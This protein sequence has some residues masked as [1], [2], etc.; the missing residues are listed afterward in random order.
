MD[1]MQ[2]FTLFKRFKNIINSA[3]FKALDNI[4]GFCHGCYKYDRNV[5]EFVICPSDLKRTINLDVIY[6]L[7]FSFD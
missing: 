3:K 4:L 1:S 7:R 5:V 2:N 6:F